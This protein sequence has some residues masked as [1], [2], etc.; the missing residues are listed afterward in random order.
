MYWEGL[1]KEGRDMVAAERSPAVPALRPAGASEAGWKGLFVHRAEWA[2]W[3]EPVWAGGAHRR[4]GC[5]SL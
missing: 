2:G 4:K 5:R 1:L 3:K